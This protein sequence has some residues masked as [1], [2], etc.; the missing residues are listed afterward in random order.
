MKVL[1]RQL[2]HFCLFAA[3]VASPAAAEQKSRTVRRGASP[4][5][6]EAASRSASATVSAA[7]VVQY[8]ERDV[9]PVHSKIRYTTLIVLPESEEI[10]E[11][12]VG[13]REFWVV[14]GAQ[15]LAYVKPAKEG[16]QTNLNL[17]TASGR[18]YSF[19]LS[20][21]SAGKTDPDLKVFIE[22]RAGADVDGPPRRFVSAKE[23]EESRR[24][25]EAAREEARR[26]QESS[27]AAIEAGVSRFITNVRFAYQF[28]AGKKPFYIRAMYHDDRFTYIQA[29]PEETPTLYELRDGKP[30][31]VNFDYR[32]GV[33]VATRILDEGYLV[34]GKKRLHF[35]RAE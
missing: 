25:T 22:R 11:A 17:V 29:R 16:S 13:D 24:E 5:A 1:S 28:E 35:K 2:L 14:E 7:R 18:I 19:A 20:E 12:A 4:P 33:Y 30:N 21:I 6:T 3:L 15:N 26:V 31:L 34:V 8:G 23:L 10:V 9:V 32:D 27:Q